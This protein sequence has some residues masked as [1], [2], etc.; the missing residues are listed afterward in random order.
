M[1][2]SQVSAAVTHGRSETQRTPQPSIT[3]ARCRSASRSRPSSPTDDPG[4]H[5]VVPVHRPAVL[6]RE[7]VRHVADD[8]RQPGGRQLPVGA[9]VAE[10]LGQRR[11]RSAGCGRSTTTRSAGRTTTACRRRGGPT[12]SRPGASGGRG[13]SRPPARPPAT[14]SRRSRGRRCTATGATRRRPRRRSRWRRACPARPGRP[15]STGARSRRAAA[16]RP[17]SRR[18]ARPRRGGRPA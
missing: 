13:R 6:G 11:P 9:L 12:G 1:A 3:K 4:E 14:S 5:R 10:Q 7:G 2:Y 16:G 17:A 15:G 18:P 8:V